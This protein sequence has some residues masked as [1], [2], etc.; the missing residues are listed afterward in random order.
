MNSR[1][2]TLLAPPADAAPHRDD[3]PY[4]LIITVEGGV[5]TAILP[6]GPVNAVIVDL[7]MLENDDTF[8]QRIRKSVLPIT[9][10]STISSDDISPL[11]LTIVQEY[12][13][14]ARRRP[15]PSPDGKKAA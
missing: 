6:T 10:D 2:T 13:R 12:R 11:I 5:V 4:S 15:A 14:P 8:E 7:D 9:P 3:G 1:T